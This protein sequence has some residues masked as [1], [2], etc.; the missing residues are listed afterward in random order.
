MTKRQIKISY[1]KCEIGLSEA[2]QLLM[3]EHFM[4]K[5]EAISYLLK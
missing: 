4:D 2:T 1:M 3:F 5:G